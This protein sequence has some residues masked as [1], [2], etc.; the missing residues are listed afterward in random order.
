MLSSVLS[1]LHFIILLLFHRPP[2]DKPT[3][4][5]PSA[6]PRVKLY[7]SD[8]RGLTFTQACVPT[9]FEDR[10]YLIRQRYGPHGKYT[11]VFL[12][13]DHDETDPVEAILPVANTYLSSNS[14]CVASCSFICPFVP[15]LVETNPVPNI[16]VP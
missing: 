4:A 13:V 16:V 1:T 12:A 6:Y 7:V 10:S 11:G 9:D 8:D 15:S 2:T 14:K 3:K 5:L